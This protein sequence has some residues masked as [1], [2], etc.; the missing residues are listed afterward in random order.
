M[1]IETLK[2]K[3]DE[4]PLV[5]TDIGSRGGVHDMAG[6]FSQ[7]T[8]AIGFEPGS[9]E[10]ERLKKCNWTSKFADSTFFDIALGDKTEELTLHITR[11]ETNTSALQPCKHYID[12]YNMIK[13]EEIDKCQVNALTLDSVFEERNES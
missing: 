2:A 9:E 10:I 3:L 4:K 7:I 13:W 1:V 6:L 12:R 5:F 8:H 11:A